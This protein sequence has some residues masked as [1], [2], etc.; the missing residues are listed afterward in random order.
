MGKM[1]PQKIKLRL[2]IQ[3]HLPIWKVSFQSSFD[4]NHLSHPPSSLFIPKSLS[5][6]VTSSSRALTI[7]WGGS[8]AMWSYNIHCF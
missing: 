4:L 7:D 3:P 1:K 5:L 2:L 8:P 6:R